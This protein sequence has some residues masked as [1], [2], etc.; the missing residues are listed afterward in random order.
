MNEPA[1]DADGIRAAVREHLLSDVLVGEDPENLTDDLP[2]RT[3]GVIDSMGVIRLT[4]FLEAR[5]SIRIEAH[6]TGVE[7]TDTVDAIVS[8]VESK[9]AG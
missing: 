4:G 3:S 8:F 2:L 1:D 7:N 5:F 9:L 6:E